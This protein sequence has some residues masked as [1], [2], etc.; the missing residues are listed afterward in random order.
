MAP[1]LYCVGS[2]QENDPVLVTGN[3]KL[4]ID[5]LRKC[6]GHV[7]AWILIIDT[8]GINVWCAAGKRTFSTAEIAYQVNHCNLAEIVSHRKLIIPQ[9]AAPGVSGLGLKERCGFTG[10]FGPVR[11]EDIP[12]FL[13]NEQADEQMR[14]VSFTLGERAVL[15]PVE[16]VLFWKNLMYIMLA[17]LVLSGAAFLIQGKALAADTALFYFTTTFLGIG[18]GAILFPILLP[19]LPFTQFWLKG[20]LLGSVVSVSFLFTQTA[21]SPITL[22]AGGLWCTLLSAFMA[23][24]FTGSTPFT[25]LS[26][27]EKEVK[28]AIP[29]LVFGTIITFII[30]VLGL[31]L[32]R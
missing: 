1:G 13:A 8:R 4:T 14:S 19:L 2:P 9:L 20:T 6:L 3:Y 12:Y 27:V 7:T 10:V 5:S 29:F 23:M 28:T 16:I 25:S 17:V 22:I 26:G 15:T 30:A 21:F 18:C 31:F 32:S 24:N 11:A